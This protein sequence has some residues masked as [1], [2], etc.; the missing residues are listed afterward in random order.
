MT[1]HEFFMKSALEL[2]LEAYEAGE[3]PIGAV[4]VKDNQVIGT[5]RNRIEELK[6]A[7][8]HAEVLAIRS[9]ATALKNWR[10][11]DC[12]VYST[13]EPCLMCLGAIL[14]SRLG[15]LCYGAKEPVSGAIE[16]KHALKG[17]L[18]VVSGILSKD[19][20]DLIQ[21]FFKERR[22]NN[23]SKKFL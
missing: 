10:L 18:Q 16:S 14:N 22:S 12:T 1:D 9:A 5:G 21:R 11:E 7:T 17:N 13:L 2:A 3:V 20:K 23:G 15:I 6:D 4:I 19:S 8:A